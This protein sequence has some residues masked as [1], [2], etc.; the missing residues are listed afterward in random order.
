MRRSQNLYVIAIVIALFVIVTTVGACFWFMGDQSEAFPIN[1][2]GS[3]IDDWMDVPGGGTG[4][5]AKPIT[6]PSEG[7]QDPHGVGDDHHSR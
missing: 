2:H 4:K 7:S 5:T 1:K 6:I 3:S